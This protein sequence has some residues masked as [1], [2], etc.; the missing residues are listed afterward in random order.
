MSED[1]VRAMQWEPSAASLLAHE[2]ALIKIAPLIKSPDTVVIKSAEDEAVAQTVYALLDRWIGER[3]E[4]LAAALKP[5]NDAVKAVRGRLKPS[6]EVADRRLR[7]IEAGLREWTMEQW[8]IAQ[9][10]QE[11]ANKDYQKRLEAAKD[12]DKVKPPTA[13]AIPEKSAM[14]TMTGDKL[15]WADNWVVKLCGTP[16]EQC[17]EWTRADGRCNGLPDDLFKLDTAMMAR[18]GKAGKGFNPWPEA[19]VTIANEPVMKR[20]GAK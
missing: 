17:K 5:L 20:S 6:L 8:R 13:V 11:K 14:E 19:A 16:L 7:Q 3:E 4:E 2:Q 18:M 12:P 15:S 10:T 1:V 9:A